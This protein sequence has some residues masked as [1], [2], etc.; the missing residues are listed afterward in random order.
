[1]P[2]LTFKGKLL[3]R[4][5]KHSLSVKRKIPY[6]DEYTDDMGVW[7]V[8]DQGIYVMAPTHEERDKDEKGHTFVC[9]A[10][11]YRGEVEDD[12]LW[13]RTHAV[14]GDDFAEFIPLGEEMVERILQAD[15]R[16]HALKINLFESSILVEA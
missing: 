10:N 1:M 6:V 8:K 4:V 11:G 13:D 16:A 3:K 9:D 12:T 7:L 5:V 15:N 14:S 2:E